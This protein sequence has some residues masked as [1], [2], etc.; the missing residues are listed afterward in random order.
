M[1]WHDLRG[2]KFFRNDPISLI[3]GRQYMKKFTDQQDKL[4]TE[5]KKELEKVAPPS[6]AI[7]P[8][9]VSTL[10]LK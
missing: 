9:Q 6:Q 4:A 2:L 8:K 1:N 10:K 3:S 7:V 5:T